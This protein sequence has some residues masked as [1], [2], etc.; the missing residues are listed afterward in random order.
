MY[1]IKLT[2]GFFTFSVNGVNSVQDETDAR[3]EERPEKVENGS[4]PEGS[5][6]QPTATTSSTVS[7]DTVYELPQE[8]VDKSGNRDRW[9]QN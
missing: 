8:K 2:W 6:E 4:S 3:L 5:E 9:I 1:V 7:P